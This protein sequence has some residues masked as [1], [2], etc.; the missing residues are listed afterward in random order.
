M[1]AGVTEQKVGTGLDGL[2]DSL[3]MGACVITR[4]LAIVDWNQT[5][6][7]WTG[8]SHE[9]AIGGDLGNLAPNLRSSR[10][11]SRIM[12]VFDLG[13]TAV[14]S[15]AIHKRFLPVAARHGSGE[16][17]M[18]QQTLVRLL[19]GTSGLAVV[20]IQDVTSEYEQLEALRRERTELARLHTTLQEQNVRLAHLAT[21]DEL[22]GV[23]NRRRFSED[24][25][26]HAAL[27]VRQHLP[28]S[29][30]MV[31]VDHFKN[32]NDAF[33]HLAGDEALRTVARLLR[34]EVRQQDVVARYGGEE[35]VILLPAT[36][37]AAAVE[38]TERPR[39]AVEKHWKTTHPLTASFGVATTTDGD[40]LD[41][42]SLVDL[43][44]QALYHAKGLGR[45]RV[46]HIRDLPDQPIS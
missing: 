11:Y 27:A 3:P 34:E 39:L 33:G 26:L 42:D 19:P 44:D 6:T 17:L 8:I 46:C 1:R 40:A 5:L 38:V 43:A 41:A 29:L 9:S 23:K 12:D 28:L 14:F 37:V 13:T 15:S 7:D 21:T 31:D 35:F 32:Y 2:L 4:D 25:E 18:I 24:L 22:T 10:F 20:T 36:D 45:N 16:E 30:V